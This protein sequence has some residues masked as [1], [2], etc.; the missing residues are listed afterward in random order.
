VCT[1]GPSTLTASGANTYVWDA[2]AG[3]ATTPGTIVNPVSTSVYT[4]QGTYASTGCQSTKTVEVKVFTPTITVTTPTSTCFGGNITLVASGANPNSYNW[5]TGSGFTNPFQTIAV[6]PTVFT[7]YTVSAISGSNGVN[8][9]S[10]QTTSVD[11]FYNPT[12]TAVPERTFFCRGESLQIY[13][14]GGVSYSW[15]NSQTGGTITVSPNTNTNYTVTG[16]DANGCVSTGTLQ[17]K[18]SS[19]V[20]I[21]ELNGANQS[22]SI[23]PNPNTGEFS[24]QSEGNANLNLVNELGQLI[25][26]LKLN[27]SNNYKIDVSELPNGIYFVAGDANGVKVNQKIIVSQ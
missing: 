25:R 26:T 8:C 11:I 21:T 2:T 3:G 12:I 22:V 1:T 27:A 18:V 14:N 10:T 17:V 23:Y 6:T 24:I 4:V 7:V 15:S 5:N 9:A 13:G 19:C 20:G 16:T